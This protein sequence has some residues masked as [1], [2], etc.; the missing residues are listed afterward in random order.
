MALI[1]RPAGQTEALSTAYTSVNLLPGETTERQR[2][3]KVAHRFVLAGV[4]LAVVCGGIWLAQ[5]K[6]INSAEDDLA[7]AE[8]AHADSK[9]QL[10]PLLPIKSFSA[11]IDEQQTLVGTSMATHTS[12]SRAMTGFAAAWPAGSTMRTMDATLGTTCAGPDPFQ[13]APSIGCLTWS[14][15]VPGEQQ[16]RDLTA[17]IPTSPGLVAPYLTGAVRNEGTFDASGTVNFDVQLLTGRFAD[18]LEE[19]TP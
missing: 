1:T 3:R 9:A 6:A 16:V 15:T 4:G 12:F 17:A 18:L 19:V 11:S 13:P 7:A 5:A 10:A 14:V 8:Q 2:A